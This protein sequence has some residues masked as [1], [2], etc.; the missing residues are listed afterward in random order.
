VLA[1][2]GSGGI[3]GLGGSGDE[4]TYH[5]T[6]T[7]N[8]RDSS[9][10]DTL[11]SK[12]SWPLATD[13]VIQSEN[14]TE[15]RA[16]IE[17][18]GELV[19]ADATRIRHSID[20][21]VAPGTLLLTFGSKFRVTVEDTVACPQTN[22]P[23]LHGSTVLHILDGHVRGGTTDDE[24]CSLAGDILYARFFFDMTGDRVDN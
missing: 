2:G 14:E 8:T 11:P 6:I 24:D 12:L 9:P 21:A 4:G 3:A 18:F 20:P 16:Q 13:L 15:H 7:L 1:V 19:D 5:L 10:L 22:P 17:I 23:S